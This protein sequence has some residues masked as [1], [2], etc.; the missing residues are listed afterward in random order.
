[1]II[2]KGRLNDN[3]A[4]AALNSFFPVNSSHKEKW[5]Q[6]PFLGRPLLRMVFSN[7]NKNP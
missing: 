2:L 4:V 7:P 1:V 5:C 6:E 3:N